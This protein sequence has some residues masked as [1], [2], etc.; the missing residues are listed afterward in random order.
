MTAMKS[1][2]SK[3]TANLLMAKAKP[4][5]FSLH[6]QFQMAVSFHS[7]GRWQDAEVL[8]DSIITAQPGHADVWHMRGMLHAQA[9]EHAQ[10]VKLISQAILLDSTKSSYFNNR[11]LALLTQQNFAEALSDFQQ[12]IALEPGLAQAH[13]NMGNVLQYSKKISCFFL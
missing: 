12:A 11:G 9:G 3:Q 10:A 1:K 5:A 13:C 6:A 2:P 8:Y 7:Q 4:A